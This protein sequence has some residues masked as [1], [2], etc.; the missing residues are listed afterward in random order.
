MILGIGIQRISL[1]LTGWIGSLSSPRLLL[2][3]I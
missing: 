2:S 1:L 3:H